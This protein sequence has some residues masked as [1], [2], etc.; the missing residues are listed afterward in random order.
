ME[1]RC[2]A[3]IKGIERAKTI[4]IRESPLHQNR[5][6]S[7]RERQTSKV[8]NGQGVRLSG[9]DLALGPIL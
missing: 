3:R 2:T 5:N 6:Q 4:Q 8:P 1:E 9:R 7:S